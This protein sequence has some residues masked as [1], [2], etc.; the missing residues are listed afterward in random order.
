M[1]VTKLVYFFAGAAF[2]LAIGA[3][4]FGYNELYFFAGLAGCLAAFMTIVQ[5]AQ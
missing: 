5:R 4:G 1:I 2:F 3:A